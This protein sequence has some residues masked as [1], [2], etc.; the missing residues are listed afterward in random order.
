[1]RRLAGEKIDGESFVARW[2]HAIMFYRWPEHVFTTIYIAFAA[3]VLLTLWLVPPHWERKTDS[4][5]ATTL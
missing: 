3:A 2:T 4:Q 5:D 1:M